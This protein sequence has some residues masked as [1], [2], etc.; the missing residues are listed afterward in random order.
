[1]ACLRPRTRSRRRCWRSR[2]C[3]GINSSGI[4][5]SRCACADRSLTRPLKLPLSALISVQLKAL[6]TSNLSCSCT[7]SFCMRMRMLVSLCRISVR[8][9]ILLQWLEERRIQCPAFQLI[10]TLTRSLCGRININSFAH[11]YEC[12]TNIFLI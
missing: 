7:I 9:F 8:I 11:F 4:R 3:Y 1:M 5:R 12:V 10:W 6:T 2:C